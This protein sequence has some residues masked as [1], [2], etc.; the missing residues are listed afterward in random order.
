M[1]R[2][3]TRCALLCLAVCVPVAIGADQKAKTESGREVI[4]HDDGTWSY[5]DAGKGKSNKPAGEAK[6]NALPEFTKDKRAELQYK[7]K[8]GTFALYLVPG[9]WKQSEHS[10]NA[11]AEVQFVGKDGDAM[12]LVIA[13][14]LAIPLEGLK[15]SALDTWG[16]SDK[17]F[18]L[19][20]EEKRIV[21]G[22]EVLCLTANVT[23]KGI[24]F[25]FYGYYYSG[26]EGSIQL[27]T[28]TGQN[29]FDE[30]KPDLE[31]FL[32]GFTVTSK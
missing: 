3:P 31:A 30:L 9:A 6:T 22:K 20:K 4:L 25:T 21:N 1:S 24:P 8:R 14:R 13:E 28:W 19:L 29:L 23:A 15:T 17:D 27:V 16:K 12:A 10:S 11:A 32:N 5:A 18:K 7:G 2:L 26:K